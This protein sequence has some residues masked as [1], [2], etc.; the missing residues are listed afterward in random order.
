MNASFG[1]GWRQVA[2]CLFLMASGAMVSSAYGIVAVP[3]DAE[4]R[5]S[6]MVLMLT[7]TVMSL[8]SGLLAPLAGSLMDRVSLRLMMGA[9]A[10]SLVTGFALL[11]L[12][13]SF[14]QVLVI[15]GVFMAP[16]NLLVGPMAAAVLLSRWFVRR[17]GTALGIAVSGVALGGF[18]FPP[19]I[20][21]LLDNHDWRDA[22]RILA[23]VVA[24]CTLPAA[25]LVVDRPSDKGL[26]PDGAATEPPGQQAAGDQ[27]QLSTRAL[28]TD[29]TFWI[30]AVV[31]S[32][33]LSGMMGMVTNLPPLAVGQ[34]ID[35][36]AAALLIS[37][38][39]ATGFIAK[40]AFA[41][42]ADRL[43][44]RHLIFLSLAGFAS[45]MACLIGADLGYGMIAL[46][47]GIAG[48]FGGV[49][50]PLQALLVPRIFGPHV[51]GRVSGIL[52]LVVLGALLATPPIFGLIF[53]MTGSYDAIFVTFAALSLATM[54]LVPHMRLPAAGGEPAEP[55]AG[56]HCSG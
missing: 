10:V 3:L 18:V 34:G 21:F 38:Y 24:L 44:L 4:F 17:R 1:T 39:A 16:A 22:L 12:A 49:M 53:D 31:M 36:A 54:L 43:N 50:V 46:G 23:I 51:V 52:N 30:V 26:H 47:V 8:V 6:R 27:P 11:S 41:A 15:Y 9:G 56:L 25:A 37:V 48:L 20:Q 2:A 19:L 33:V 55:N 14:T 45:G 32:V 28:L 7:I 40:L 13:T 29:P 35:P 42:V 5:P